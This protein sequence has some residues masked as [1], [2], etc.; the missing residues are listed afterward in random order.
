M[1]TA[2]QAAKV[3]QRTATMWLAR[4]D[5]RTL[6]NA[7][8]E[9]HRAAALELARNRLENAVGVAVDCLVDLAG[10]PSQDPHA[11]EKAAR[12]ILDRAGLHPRQEVR[13]GPAG[14]IAGMSDAALLAAVPTAAKVLEAHAKAAPVLEAPGAD[15]SEPDTQDE[16]QGGSKK[17]PPSPDG[18]REL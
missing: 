4:Q 18:T 12:A 1:T 3:P 2:A 8:L 7:T 16:G 5:V 13:I 17:V 11:R 6:L 14:E 15:A 9:E 10:D